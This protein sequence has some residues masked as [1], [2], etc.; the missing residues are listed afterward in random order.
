MN[1]IDQILFV[2]TLVVVAI[3]VLVLAYYLLGII[4]ALRQAN[5]NLTKLAAGLEAIQRNT[6]ALG[7]DLGKINGAAVILRDGL[8][9]V[10]GHL[11]KVT[12]G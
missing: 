2:A 11:A 4:V 1:T 7:G 8:S 10:A 5:A 6:D 3:V 12:G 9:S